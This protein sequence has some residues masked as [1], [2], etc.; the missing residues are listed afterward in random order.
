MGVVNETRTT[1]GAGAGDYGAAVESTEPTA[2]PLA[3]KRDRLVTAA[4][5][6]PSVR[7][8]ERG[9]RRV[10]V[11][12]KDGAAVRVADLADIQKAILERAKI[13][14][15]VGEGVRPKTVFCDECGTVVRVGQR[16]AVIKRCLKCRQKHWK[17]AAC[18][19]CGGRIDVSY[20][21]KMVRR[22]GTPVCLSCSSRRL[23]KAHRV[24]RECGGGVSRWT[25]TRAK[26]HD[27]SAVCLPCAKKKHRKFDRD[28]AQSMRSAG[29]TW[30]AIGSALGVSSAAVIRALRRMSATP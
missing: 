16:G 6:A 27:K 29:H 4:V 10:T 13:E 3:T 14:L 9:K 28:R 21:R 19:G 23:H 11:V 24:C 1:G 8:T 15:D 5:I 2:V 17:S 25:S 20:A 30:A 22:G 7:K 26:Q 12:D 18:S